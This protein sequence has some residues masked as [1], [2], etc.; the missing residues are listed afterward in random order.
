MAQL[1]KEEINKKIREA[2]GLLEEV[3]MLAATN[4]ISDINVLCLTHDTNSGSM[5]CCGS[6]L[7]LTGMLCI[8]AAQHK[9]IE[10]MLSGCTPLAIQKAR[11]LISEAQIKGAGNSRNN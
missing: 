10:T 7:E 1:T 9:F 4:K 3:A 11:D 5:I 2:V 8:K 6:P